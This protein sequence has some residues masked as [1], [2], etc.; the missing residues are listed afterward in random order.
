MFVWA[1]HLVP[2]FRGSYIRQESDGN[3][4]VFLSARLRSDLQVRPSLQRNTDHFG[5]KGARRRICSCTTSIISRLPFLP[6]ASPSLQ[7]NTDPFG[8][9]GVRLCTHSETASTVSKVPFRP[10]ARCVLTFLLAAVLLDKH[11]VQRIVLPGAFFYQ[12]I[13]SLRTHLLSPMVALS[14]SLQVEDVSSSDEEQVSPRFGRNRCYGGFVSE[15]NIAIPPSMGQSAARRATDALTLKTM[16]IRKDTSAENK[17]RPLSRSTISHFI[18][19]T[20]WALVSGMLGRSQH[21]KPIRSE[22]PPWP[23]L[24]VVER[25]GNEDVLPRLQIRQNRTGLRCCFQP[26]TI[27]YPGDR[28]L[29]MR[30]VWRWPTTSRAFIGDRQQR[31]LFW[32]AKYQGET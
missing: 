32:L 12:R 9:R 28:E 16:A 19:K 5:W 18:E 14:R 22:C 4:S 13:V 10:V 27:G 11:T 31:A 17:V 15:S 20:L 24:C 6:T 2:S 29:L 23:N 1:Q 26:D 25:Q 7:R 21:I 30:A 3:L 8:W